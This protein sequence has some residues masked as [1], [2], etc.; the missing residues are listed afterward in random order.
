MDLISKMANSVIAVQ[1]SAALGQ[2]LSPAILLTAIS[3]FLTMIMNRLWRVLDLSRSHAPDPQ[4]SLDAEAAASLVVLHQR[5]RLLYRCIY[6]CVC[7][8]VAVIT[9]VL[10]TF[11]NRVFGSV[12]DWGVGAVFI[13]AICLFGVAFIYLLREVRLA[14]SEFERRDRKLLADRDV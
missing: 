8:A 11:G 2:A 9:V 13:I 14:V 10:L 6:A 1:Y 12:Q 3:A 7:S 5:A 4:Q